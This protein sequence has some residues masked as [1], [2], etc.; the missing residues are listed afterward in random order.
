M[1]FV[2]AKIQCQ[3]EG[4]VNPLDEILCE[5]PKVAYHSLTIHANSFRYLFSPTSALYRYVPPKIM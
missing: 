4:M 1:T 3:N 2:L 5:S